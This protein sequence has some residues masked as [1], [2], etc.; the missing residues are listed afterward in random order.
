MVTSLHH[1]AISD[2]FPFTCAFED[3]V[4]CRRLSKYFARDVR[5]ATL[6]GG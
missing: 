4:G 5:K 1:Q 3:E 2:P 6:S